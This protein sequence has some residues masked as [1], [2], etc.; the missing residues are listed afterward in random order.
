VLIAMAE[1]IWVT[2]QSLINNC[3]GSCSARQ[4]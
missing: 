2:L 3:V 4:V 1:G